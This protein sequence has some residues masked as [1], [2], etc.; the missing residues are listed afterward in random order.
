MHLQNISNLDHLPSLLFLQ[1][2]RRV[3][4]GLMWDLLLQSPLKKLLPIIYNFLKE[5]FG[6]VILGVFSGL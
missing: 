3:I 6:Q 1:D 2:Q 4:Y 5:Y